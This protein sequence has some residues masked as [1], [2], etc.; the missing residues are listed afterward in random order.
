MS[1]NLKTKSDLRSQLDDHPEADEENFVD[2]GDDSDI[3]KFT[4]QTKKQQSMQ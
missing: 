2:V 4:D 1:E 3:E